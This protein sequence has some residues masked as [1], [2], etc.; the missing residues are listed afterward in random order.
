MQ[1]S[2][3][4]LV[5]HGAQPYNWHMSRDKRSSELVLRDDGALD[6]MGEL[7]TLARS[8]IDVHTPLHKL[9]DENPVVLIC[10]PDPAA[11]MVA[12]E[13]IAFT[14]RRTAARASR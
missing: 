13:C 6:V 5:N 10:E 7:A 1:V 12:G 2:H 4:A 11:A 8:G 3:Q 14:Q 9:L